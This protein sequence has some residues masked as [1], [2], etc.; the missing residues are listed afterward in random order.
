MS[1]KSETFL[2]NDLFL[3]ATDRGGVFSRTFKA[4]HT[5]YKRRKTDKKY[6]TYNRQV[7]YSPEVGRL[8]TS[9]PM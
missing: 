5:W 6:N 7:F 2:A 9:F 4:L 3:L 1:I 8:V